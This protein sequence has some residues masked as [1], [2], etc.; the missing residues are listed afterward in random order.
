MLE[1]SR[2][3]RPVASFLIR[4]V[5][6]SLV[7][8]IVGLLYWS[9]LL[10][11][12]ELKGVRQELRQL[13]SE[14]ANLKVAN[15]LPVALAR[16]HIDPALS[17][18]LQE[19]PFYQQTLP[20]LLPAGFKPHGTLRTADLGR[21][22]DFHPFSQWINA[23][24]V[25]VACVGALGTRWVGFYEEYSPD[26]A[27]KIEE[28]RTEVGPEYWVHLREGV[29][30]QPLDPG[31]FPSEMALSP[32][33]FER[34]PVT[35]QDFKFC[36]DAI[37]NPHVQEPM[38]ASLRPHF[39]DL[40]E[41]R[42]L[43]DLTFVVRWKAQEVVHP[44]GS[45][46]LKPKY[47]AWQMTVGLQPL[48]AWVY[49]YF[50][51][52]TKIV[53]EK[54]ADEY[55]TNSVWAQNFGQ[56][57]AKN[58]LVSCGP[59]MLDK[60]TDREVRLKR[61]PNHHEP[62]AAL[63]EYQVT[64]FKSSPDS[65]WQDFKAGLI[66]I[67]DS[68]FAPQKLLELEDFL[69]SDV[70]TGQLHPIRRIDYLQRSFR[71]VAWNQARPLFAS[72]EVRRALTMAID[73]RRLIEQCLGSMGIETSGPFCPSDSI[74]DRT[75]HPYPYDPL[76]AKAL[77]RSAGWEDRDGDGI[78]ERIIGGE[79]QKFS[80]KLIYFAHSHHGRLIADAITSS[81][82][83]IGVECRPVGLDSADIAIA[84][85]GK[86]FDAVC[87]GWILSLPDS[88]PTQIWHSAGAKEKGSSN[89]VGF[90]NPEADSIIEHLQFVYDRVEREK[91]FH[92]FHGIIHREEPYTFL[93]VP[94]VSLLYRDHVRNIFTPCD[95]PDLIPHANVTEPVLQVCWLSEES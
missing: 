28:R 9:S 92:R 41:F 18:L 49:Q 57:W 4:A 21:P 12:A 67:F 31:H 64:Y 80:F 46:E 23:V 30:W 24:R 33:F 60:L 75:L 50:P 29:Y 84:F 27:I 78:V 89:A 43:D 19:D 16:R 85:E 47:V 35:A 42:V 25:Y 87:L 77:L 63:T 73:R 7:L 88:D 81:L 83:E 68:H 91:L 56:H 72:A 52:G 10:V 3:R 59:W 55:R 66:D 38:A 34:H 17:N 76:E 53:D 13:R 58:A 5:I 51:D 2:S 54:N 26:L 15:S 69:A 48:P 44:D 6:G 22:Q 65:I 40:V 70:Y 93:Y 37:C 39:K 95:R 36:F 61:N 32:H 82:R 11:E 14:L 62:F 1:R 8:A 79:R 86:D 20:S 94:R 90:A 71:F 74:Y 45:Q